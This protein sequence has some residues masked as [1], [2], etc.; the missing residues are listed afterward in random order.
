MTQA[1]DI[2]ALSVADLCHHIAETKAFM[3]RAKGNL[4]ALQQELGE[5]LA[6]QAQNLYAAAGKV[7]GDITFEEGG[8]KFKASISKTVKWDNAKLQTIA[9]GMDW[10]AA[11]RIF[12]IKFEVSESTFKAM[13]DL[14]LIAKLEEARSETTGELKIEPII[15]KD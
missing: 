6:P 7:N 1:V 11:Q 3:V 9:A 8:Q 5:R 12:K 10:A 13:T 15:N 4:D 2:K 14:E